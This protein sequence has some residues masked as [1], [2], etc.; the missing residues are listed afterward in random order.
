MDKHHSQTE[1]MMRKSMLPELI[2]D[3]MKEIIE[4][5]E[6][7][8][9]TLN[10][11][12]E[13][14]NP[15]RDL[16]KV[17]DGVRGPIR[18]M[19]EQYERIQRLG[20]SIK[21]SDGLADLFPHELSIQ[22]ADSFFQKNEELMGLVTGLRFMTSEAASDLIRDIQKEYPEGQII[23]NENKELKFKPSQDADS[24]SLPELRKQRGIIQFL[25]QISKNELLNFENHLK[26]FPMM[27][28]E[29]G[30]GTGRKILDA[31]RN[32]V[33]NTDMCI[34]E[35]AY[36]A[37]HSR[38]IDKGEELPLDQLPVFRLDEMFGP[39]SGI[40][41]QGRFNLTGQSVM[42]TCSDKG[43]TLKE[44]RASKGDFG[45]I[46]RFKINRQ[47]KVLDMT[48]GNHQLFEHCLLPIEEKPGQKTYDEYLLSNFIAQCCRYSD[49]DVIRYKSVQHENCINH[50]F[51]NFP[52]YHSKDSEAGTF[53]VEELGPIF[54]WD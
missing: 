25:P 15:V 2:D 36:R 42:Y 26:E 43:A 23:K 17:I 9:P 28:L 46:Y 51:F 27:A 41:G 38:N 10:L 8:I 45:T 24:Q 44:I 31:I 50:V 52:A 4:P 49:I 53:R 32:M 1:K 35:L 18:L 22:K 12:D 3:Q 13:I 20:D 16:Q 34:D 37:R 33:P 14:R 5:I 11:N 19:E 6:S 39:P 48:D 54:N 21:L 30:P 40:S 29:D 7:I 47:F